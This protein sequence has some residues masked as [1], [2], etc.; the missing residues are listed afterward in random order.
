MKKMFLWAWPLMLIIL[1]GITGAS[2]SR[3][4]AKS[5][6]KEQFKETNQGNSVPPRAE[7][8]APEKMMPPPD[9]GK[10][11]DKPGNAGGMSFAKRNVTI[12]RV[13]GADIS[14]NELASEMTMLGPQFIKDPSQK[15]PE[16]VAKLKQ[17]AFDI[18]IFRELATQ[19]AARQGMKVRHEAVEE[20]DKQLRT[21]LGSEEN[22]RKFLEMSGYNGGAMKRRLEKDLLFEMIVDKE[23][24]KKVGTKDQAA[25]EKR[26]AAWEN[27]L[28]KNA[29]I[30][31]FLPE[32][33]KKI[34][35]EAKK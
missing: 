31:I 34:K 3:E 7:E 2:C 32:I 26:K 30:E 12:A 15:T 28:K 18:L 8:R 24:F 22:Y 9:H 25:I 23:I 1:I 6:N 35:E 17:T 29:K 4:Q 14:M 19:E 16:N 11:S 21:N 33:E 20:A 10:L 5:Q 13:N 27:S